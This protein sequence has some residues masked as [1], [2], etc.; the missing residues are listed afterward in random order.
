MLFRSD[1]KYSVMVPMYLDLK[2]AEMRMQLRDY[3]LPILYSPRN[4]NTANASLMLRGDLVISE[5]YV[6]DEKEI[7][8]LQVPLVASHKD[9][10]NRYDLLTIEKTL[11][12][13]KMYTKMDCD[14]NSDYPTRIVWGTSYNFGIQQF[15][16]NFD[17]FSKPPVD[18]SQKLG[19][20]DKLK[21]ILHGS[22]TIKTR[23][24]LEVG[25]RKSVV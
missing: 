1:T 11:S 2:L 19:F 14:F 20:W 22:C 17:Q 6:T 9:E 21:Y 15:M 13:I 3:P 18:P 16:L 10:A 4:K 12:S 24:S 5:K 23:K 7:R 8:Q 25:D